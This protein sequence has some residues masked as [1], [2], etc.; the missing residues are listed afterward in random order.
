[1]RITKII[2]DLSDSIKTT[3]GI[4][5][6]LIMEGAIY[7]ME[8]LIE[9]GVLF[10]KIVD[11]REDVLRQ[12]TTGVSQIAGTITKIYKYNK[13]L[14]ADIELL[15]NKFGRDL[16]YNHNNFYLSAVIIYGNNSP[17]KLDS[18]DNTDISVQVETIYA[19]DITNGTA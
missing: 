12:V 18:T 1:M 5:F 6:N 15:N 19:R 11:E 3:N 17:I 10:V 16:L 8:N 13:Y 2:F 9:N 7:F 4:D 14:I